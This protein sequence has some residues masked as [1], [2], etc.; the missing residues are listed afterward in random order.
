MEGKQVMQI[1]HVIKTVYVRQEMTVKEVKH[2][3]KVMKDL[4]AIKISLIAIELSFSD[5]WEENNIF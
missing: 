3:R 2:K 5:L 1:I 4:L